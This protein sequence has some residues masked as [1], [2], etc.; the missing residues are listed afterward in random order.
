MVGNFGP[1]LI[2]MR[3]RYPDRETMGTLAFSDLDV[4]MVGPDSAYVFGRWELTRAEDRPHG[5]FTLILRRLPAG[6]R[7]RCGEACG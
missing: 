1:P 6:W 2:M 7:M 5:L 3:A 4:V